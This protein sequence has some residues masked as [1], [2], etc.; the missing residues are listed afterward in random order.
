MS[1]RGIGDR[2][3]CT[4]PQLLAADAGELWGL[5][6]SLRIGGRDFLPGAVSREWRCNINC[7]EWTD[8]A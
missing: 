3:I 2:E 7:A 8:V 4:K 1:R 5:L 6:G